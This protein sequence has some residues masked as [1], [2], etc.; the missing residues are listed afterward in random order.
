MN[1]FRSM[2]IAFIPWM[3]LVHLRQEDSLS[4]HNGTILKAPL[5][6]K[7]QAERFSHIGVVERSSGIDLNQH[8]EAN[9]MSGQTH[10]WLE[11]LA[12]CHGFL[13]CLSILS[14]HTAELYAQPRGL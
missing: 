1:G 7:L 9:F 10:Q 6:G 2:H 14:Y 13:V 4:R 11:V 8:G 5:A 3:P 12:M